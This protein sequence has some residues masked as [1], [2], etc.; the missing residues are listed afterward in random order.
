MI[1]I[2]KKSIRVKF[3]Q[4][5]R[6]DSIRWIFPHRIR[7][8]IREKWGYG[9]IDIFGAITEKQISEYLMKDIAKNSTRS[10]YRHTW[11]ADLTHAFISY[12]NMKWMTCSRAISDLIMKTVLKD[13][14]DEMSDLEK[15]ALMNEVKYTFL[16][17]IPKSFL[18]K[19]GICERITDSYVGYDPPD[20]HLKVF[21]QS[22]KIRHPDR[23]LPIELT[24][25]FGRVI[26][27]KKLIP[28]EYPE[29]EGISENGFVDLNRD[30]ID[31]SHLWI[32]D[33]KVKGGILDYL[34]YR[35]EGA[36][37]I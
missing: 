17:V 25:L 24:S 27:Q 33:G 30:Q 1:V 2:F 3:H 19:N 31:R 28:I 6:D 16:G 26:P 8:G 11:K 12:A 34:K 22:L 35:S 7:K 36:M 18:W 5:K 20:E 37:N 9:N 32:Q 15:I 4:N 23:D 21:A 14:P 10:R 13:S 29:N